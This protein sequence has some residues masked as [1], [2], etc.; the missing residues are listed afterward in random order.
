M[1]DRCPDLNLVLCNCAPCSSSWSPLPSMAG[2]SSHS[3][4]TLC[5]IPARTGALHSYSFT[6]NLAHGVGTCRTTRKSKGI[7][8]AQFES[9][10]DAV[11]AHAALDRSVFQGRL[12]HILPG[13]RPPPPPEAAVRPRLERLTANCFVVTPRLTG[14]HI[15]SGYPRARADSTDAV[16]SGRAAG[17]KG[18]KQRERR[19]GAGTR[20]TGRPGTACSCG[21][22]RWR[23]PLP[24]TTASPRRAPEPGLPA[25]EE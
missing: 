19:R 5:T 2:P 4:A 14:S 1:L 11:A 12:L 10:A 21:R 16:S 17:G 25:L 23:K 6:G 18:L 22:T 15:K 20:A 7:A 8:L 3:Q 13:Q 9:P 24:R